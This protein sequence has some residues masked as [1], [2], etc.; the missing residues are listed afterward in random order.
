MFL[1]P[2]RKAEGARLLGMS[3]HFERGVA[4]INPADKESGRTVRSE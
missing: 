1:G 4:A 2:S 3:A